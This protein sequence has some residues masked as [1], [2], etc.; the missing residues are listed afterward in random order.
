MYNI[1]AIALDA[2]G[3]DESA[4]FGLTGGGWVF[5]IAPIIKNRVPIPI[6]DMKSETF[7]PKVS[8]PK[9]IKS[10]VATTLTMPW[11]EKKG[12]Q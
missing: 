7:R 5:R 11:L 3:G 1:A 8:T 9:K 10:E 12:E 2:G 6:A 4:G